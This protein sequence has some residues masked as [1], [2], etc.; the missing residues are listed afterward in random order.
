MCLKDWYLIMRN[1]AAV[2][3]SYLGRRVPLEMVPRLVV[4]TKL[5]EHGM[6]F[7]GT[8]KVGVDRNSQAKGNKLN[9]AGLEKKAVKHAFCLN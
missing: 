2:R 3:V 6:G 7:L 4:K 1:T 8:Q 5:Y 9:D